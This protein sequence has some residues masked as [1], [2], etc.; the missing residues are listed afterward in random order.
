MFDQLKKEIERQRRLIE[1]EETRDYIRGKEAR[2][3]VSLIDPMLRALGWSVADPSQVR[4]E[5]E[6]GDNRLDYVLMG[7]DGTPLAGIEAKRLDEMLGG[8]IGKLKADSLALQNR[9]GAEYYI[10]TDGNLWRLYHGIGVTEIDTRKQ[11]MFRVS[12]SD[13]QTGECALALA[14]LWRPDFKIVPPLPAGRVRFWPTTQTP[15][16]EGWVRLSDWDN[17]GRKPKARIRFSDG[18]EHDL[19]HWNELV[20][21][22]ANWLFSRGFNPDGDKSIL[23]EDGN[24]FIVSRTKTHPSRKQFKYPKELIREPW[25]IDKYNPDGARGHLRDAIDLLT[26]CAQDPRD[27]LV[28]TISGS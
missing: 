20:E 7:E 19:K 14:Q 6:C 16:T 26:Q 4:L 10:L 3:R 22:T 11:T 23:S 27:V 13:S 1:T 25:K 2:T 24:R 28:S 5:F 12:I 17:I 8:V 15:V 21:H 18:V 9:F